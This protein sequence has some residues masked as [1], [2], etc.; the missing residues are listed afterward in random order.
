MRTVFKFTFFV[1]LGISALGFLITAFLY[2]FAPDEV[3][4][5]EGSEQVA[6][7]PDSANEVSAL[8]VASDQETAPTDEPVAAGVPPE[9]ESIAGE[10]KKETL[11][12]PEA[13]RIDWDLTPAEQGL[14]NGDWISIEGY[15]D[16]LIGATVAQY[17]ATRVLKWN[18]PSDL[19]G[20]NGMIEITSQ[21]T[22]L[23]ASEDRIISVAGLVEDPRENETIVQIN[24]MLLQEQT[25]LI[26]VTGQID[27]IAGDKTPKRWTVFLKKGVHV[28]FVGQQI[29]ENDSQ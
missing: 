26:R 5:V 18:E 27:Q 11:L 12:P 3:E 13:K 10:E 22:G 29:Q 21:S 4:L 17:T 20:T 8:T 7:V 2:I 16:D 25:I 15:Q 19:F 6:S 23:P 28:D 1:L 9:Q 24:K 14:E